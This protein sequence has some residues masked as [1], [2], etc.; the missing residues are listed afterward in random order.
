MKT[1]DI[2][3]SD[4]HF[5][6][7]NIIKY[8]NRPYTGP[9]DMTLGIE[10]EWRSKVNA[11]DRI[12]IL[13]DLGMY[14]GSRMAEIIAGLPGEKHW[15]LGN[16]DEHLQDKKYLLDLF[17]SVQY[18]KEIKSVGTDG[19]VHR[20]FM[21]HYAHRVWN[22]SHHGTWHLYGHSHGTL[23]DDPNALSMDVGVDAHAMRFLTIEDVEKHMARKTFKPIDHHGATGRA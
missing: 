7:A 5:G 2:F 13:G 11:K 22:R 23:P 1:K 4:L 15:I 6:H 17:S 16:H 8:C 19:E 21:S 14:R 9:E 3:T 18:V 10:Q 12:F 20:I